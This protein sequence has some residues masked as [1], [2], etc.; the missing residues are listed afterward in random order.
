[1]WNCYG[2]VYT[3]LCH[4]LMPRG[5]GLL[6]IMIQFSRLNDGDKA[7]EKESRIKEEEKCRNNWRYDDN[8]L[9]ETRNSFRLVCL[10]ASLP[11]RSLRAKLMSRTRVIQSSS[12]FR[13]FICQW[14]FSQLISTVC[15][16]FHVMI[17]FLKSS[18]A[19]FRCSAT[20][21]VLCRKKKLSK[22]SHT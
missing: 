4:I 18:F 1:M 21:R 9:D 19:P 16:A 12:P 8:A 22:S 5:D 3:K 2:V 14:Y 6:W 15:S 17:L 20:H 10:S 13:T 11:T 7:D